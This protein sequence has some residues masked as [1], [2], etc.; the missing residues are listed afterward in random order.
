MT[1]GGKREGAGR[2]FGTK[3]EPT[4][5]FAKRVTFL[6]KFRLEKFLEKIRKK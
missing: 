1:K 3:K 4:V 5:L 2:P 6:E